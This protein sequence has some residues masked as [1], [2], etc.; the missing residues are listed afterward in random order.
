MRI[1]VFN[2]VNVA[3]PQ[4]FRKE[5]GDGQDSASEAH[6]YPSTHQLTQSVRQGNR[7]HQILSFLLLNMLR[8]DMT[9]KLLT[10]TLSLNTTNQP[11]LNMQKTLLLSSLLL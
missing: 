4:K 5:T 8:P 6:P 9:E 7:R 10:G 11:M 2:F 3:K 1:S